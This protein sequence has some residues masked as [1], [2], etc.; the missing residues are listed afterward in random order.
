MDGVEQMNRTNT[1]TSS[2]YATLCRAQRNAYFAW[3][4]APAGQSEETIAAYLAASAALKAAQDRSA[5]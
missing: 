4:N 5:K 3:Q 1:M 2:E